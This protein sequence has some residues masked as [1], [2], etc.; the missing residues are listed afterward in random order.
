MQVSCT[1]IL[2]I[3]GAMWGPPR[4]RITTITL[5]SL[6][7]LGSRISTL[8]PSGIKAMV[9]SI[10]AILRLLEVSRHTSLRILQFLHKNMMFLC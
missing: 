9:I 8:R 4:L 6:T 10:V 1:P 2:T 3:R 7:D 5:V